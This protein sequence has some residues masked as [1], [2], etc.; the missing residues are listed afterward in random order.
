VLQLHKSE[1]FDK[2]NPLKNNR[3]QQFFV[4]FLLFF[5]KQAP[6][7][8][9]IGAGALFWKKSIKIIILKQ[10]EKNWNRSA[11]KNIYWKIKRV[12]MYFFQRLLLFFMMQAPDHL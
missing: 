4:P 8:L 2:K 11:L 12:R 9:Q 10:T 7:S 6:D 5:K 3:V 1:W